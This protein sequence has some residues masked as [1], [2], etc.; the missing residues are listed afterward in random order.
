VEQVRGYNV[1]HGGAD[2]STDVDLAD[3]EDGADWDDVETNQ[4]CHIHIE[5]FLSQ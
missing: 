1:V 3:F 4:H 2:G 5:Q